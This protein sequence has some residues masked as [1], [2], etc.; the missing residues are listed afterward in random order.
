MKCNSLLIYYKE[1]VKGK[2]KLF[3]SIAPHYRLEPDIL[4]WVSRQNARK[5]DKI[6]LINTDECDG[7]IIATISAVDEPYFGGSSAELKILY[8]CEKCGQGYYKE[9]P[10]TSFDLSEW[11]T[12]K[13]E[14]E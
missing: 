7:K 4:E 8:K 14:A 12:K 13:I 9:L 5:I 1:Q 10:Q 11:M 3:A 2:R 6:D